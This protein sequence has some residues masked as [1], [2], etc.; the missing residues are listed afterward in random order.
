MFVFLYLS[1]LNQLVKAHN[2]QQPEA[3]QEDVQEDPGR[4]EEEQME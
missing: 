1:G 3:W 2:D 4:R